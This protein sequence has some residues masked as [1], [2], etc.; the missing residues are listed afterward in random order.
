MKE[1]VT[2]IPRPTCNICGSSAV[3]DLGCRGPSTHR[4]IRDL[5]ER[6]LVDPA[7][8]KVHA[9]QCTRCGLIWA[10]PMP[11]KGDVQIQE[12]YRTEYLEGRQL[13][14]PP[15]EVI[16]KIDMLL[17]K[18][19]ATGH[20]KQAESI[21]F[22]DIGCGLGQYL[23]AAS[24]RKWH[25]TGIEL[26]NG[27]CRYIHEKYGIETVHSSFEEYMPEG[28]FDVA[29][30]V[31]LLE[32]IQDPKECLLKLHRL[33]APGGIAYI[34]VPNEESLF[35]KIFRTLYRIAGNPNAVNLSPTVSPYHLYGFSRRS[36]R[37]AFKRTG[38]DVIE[39][40]LRSGNFQI[41][42]TENDTTLS[43]LQKGIANLVLRCSYI[44][45]QGFYVEAYCRKIES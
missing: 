26:S 34:L 6:D 28:Q 17:E 30:M 37:E 1:H 5:P 20:R 40:N 7:L 16:E 11:V 25:V 44:L 12:D 35:L 23:D 13:K 42:K 39:M 24:K 15:E 33:M 22:I 21:E 19:R 18:S 10:D 43:S 2:L 27:M 4:W 8:E 14:V 32:H 45:G 41:A 9:V 29:L 31:E 3:R 38:F 36:L